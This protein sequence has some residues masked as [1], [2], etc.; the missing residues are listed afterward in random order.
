[1][2][3]QLSGHSTALYSTFWFLE[4]LGVMFDCGDGAA[5]F[6]QQKGRKVKYI[7]CSH[8]DRDHLA[9]LLQFI[10]VNSRA[11]APTIVYPKGSG[12]F[13]ALR[14]FSEKFDPHK[15]GY[16]DWIGAGSET[17]IEIKP[18]WEVQC[19]ANKH[20]PHHDGDAADKSLSYSLVNHRRKLKL[21]FINLS[22][23]EIG[24][25][26]QTKGREHIYETVTETALTYT[27]DTPL[28]PAKFWRDP[29]ILI[30][31]AT[32]LDHETASSRNQETRHSVL[33]DVI[34]MASEM[35]SLEKLVL[36]HFSC[37]YHKER[38]RETIVRTAKDC[39]LKIPIYAVCPGESVWKLFSEKPVFKPRGLQ[40]Q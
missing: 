19:Y 27:A 33:S 8:P 10:Q 30:H 20:L 37:R 28:E 26:C 38:I 7:F 1:M 40:N 9:G 32:F 4:P 6:L 5:A 15:A 25:L 29:K 18:N 34:K 12:S 23:P 24:E 31:E 13:P 14:D 39:D 21:E 2:N 11:G 3:L 35:P 17:A 36:G 22:G 16:C